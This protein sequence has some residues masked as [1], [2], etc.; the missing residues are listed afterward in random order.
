M[1]NIGDPSVK[2]AVPKETYPGEKRVPLIPSTVADLIKRGAELDIETGMGT[3]SSYRD[4]V[5]KS[6]GAGI[7]ND[8]KALINAAD[9]ILRLRIPPA[10]EIDWIKKG[11]IHVSYLDPFNQQPLINRFK[12]NTISAIAMEL[13]PRTTKAQKMDAL[14]SQAS[15]GGYAAVVV[16]ADRLD[17]I[18]PMM[19]T[20]SGT[21]APS[22]IF[23]IGAGVA[24]LQAIA[25]AKRLGARVEAFDTRP[26]VEEQ[27]QSLGAKFVKVEL[28][29]TGET[30]DGYAKA[31]TQ[32]QL[33]QQRQVMAKHCAQSDVVITTAQV[34]GKKAPLIITSDMIKEMMPGSL[35]VDL[36]VETGG[37]V[38]GSKPGEEVDIGGVRIIGLENM[39]GRVAVHAS[40]MYSSNLGNL[41]GEFWDD[42]V[43]K[44]NLDLEDEIIK[45]CL[46]THQGKI[47]SETVK[48]I[49]K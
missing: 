9:L 7:Q 14:S 47:I 48:N 21:I 28:G 34:F 13:I 4:D 18:F 23:I 42:D 49:F 19:M 17:K 6:V 39:P 43:K 11:A 5:Y 37:N 22:K 15:L 46:V 44:F 24:G 1:I 31:L 26:T 20:P 35:I 27:V 33:E 12:E 32:E 40:Q 25:T 8:R 2:I 3:G 38:E 16:A 41:I 10:E 29:E 36:A 45:G 30:R